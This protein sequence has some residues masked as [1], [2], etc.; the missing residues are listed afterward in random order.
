GTECKADVTRRWSAE[1]SSKCDAHQQVSA[2]RDTGFNKR[3]QNLGSSFRD[4]K[5]EG[6]NGRSLIAWIARVAQHNG[7]SAHRKTARRIPGNPLTVN[8][9]LLYI[10]AVRKRHCA[11]GE[12]VKLLAIRAVWFAR[13]G[14]WLTVSSLRAGVDHDSG[15]AIR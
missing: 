2:E 13:E 15:R 11:G 12:P 6:S 7:M 8:W 3:D 4:G 5:R 14:P 9:H 10:G 1:P